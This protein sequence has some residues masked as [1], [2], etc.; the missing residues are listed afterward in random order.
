MDDVTRIPLRNKQREL[1]G[2]AIIDDTDRELV[3]TNGPWYLGGG[4][5]MQTNGKKGE[6]AVVF[7]HRFLMGLTRGDGLLV[8]HRNRDR[9]DNRRANLRVVTHLENAQNTSTGRGTSPHRGVS[10]SS[11]LSTW[12]VACQINGV[13]HYLGQF[14]DELEAAS[15]AREFRLANMSG[16]TD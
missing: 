1:M 2:H 14:N 10:W 8:D 9:L 15:V 12:V 3:E 5:A 6:K 4:Y 7:M 13:N 11:H 16:A